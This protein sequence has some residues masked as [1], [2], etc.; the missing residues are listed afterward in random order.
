MK[1]LNY[2][3]MENIHMNIY[4]VNEKFYKIEKIPKYYNVWNNIIYDVSIMFPVWDFF[5]KYLLQK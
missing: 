4:N 2:L 3:D 5:K 1:N